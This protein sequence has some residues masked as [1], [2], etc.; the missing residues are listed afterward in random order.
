MKKIYKSLLTIALATGISSVYAQSDAQLSTPLTDSEIAQK[1]NGLQVGTIT[2]S[3]GVKANCT[4]VVN[5]PVAAGNSFDGNMFDMVAT[6][7][8]TI[9][10]FSVTITNDDVIEIYARA[11]SFVGFESAAAG[12]T[13]VGSGAV[14]ACGTG[15]PVEVPTDI[16]YEMLAG[17]TH[18]FY[19]TATTTQTTEFFYTD[20]T[21][22]GTTWAS[23]ANLSIL[24]GNGG[25]Y[26]FDVTFTPRAFNGDVIY[27]LGPLAVESLDADNVS[28]YPNPANTELTISLNTIQG[29]SIATIYNIMGEEVLVENL[30]STTNEL[31]ISNLNSGVYFVKVMNNGK[32][33]TSKLIIE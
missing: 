14:T 7:D 27:C 18:A 21:A 33:I 13:L 25:A 10:T 23:D 19:V 32:E 9:E 6:N 5:C 26:P 24:E 29:T 11:G 22:V 17:S 2:P 4:N 12:W 8:V 31:N 16:A 15:V 30:S 28:M 20:G 3:E 1:L